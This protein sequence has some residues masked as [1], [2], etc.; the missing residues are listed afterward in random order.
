MKIFTL[1]LR[2]TEGFCQFGR[3]AWDFKV[4]GLEAEM[5]NQD[6]GL[7]RFR[8]HIFQQYILKLFRNK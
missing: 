4:I 2:Y 5:K 8:N 6:F 3:E 7:S 1:K